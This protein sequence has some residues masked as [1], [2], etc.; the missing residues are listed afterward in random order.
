MAATIPPKVQY[1]LL[2]NLQQSLLS[3]AR[4]LKQ[5]RSLSQRDDAM[6][7]QN[8]GRLEG[9]AQGLDFYI[10]TVNPDNGEK[11]DG[12][13]F[14][15]QLSGETTELGV[16]VDDGEAKTLFSTSRNTKRL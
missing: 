8:S 5:I 9:L 15:F 11:I 14:G 1:Q 16:D 10:E 12:K 6:V 4:E 3:V 2:K 7:S 13:A